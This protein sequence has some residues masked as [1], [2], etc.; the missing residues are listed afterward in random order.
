MS[1]WRDLVELLSRKDA[2]AQ[3]EEM[4]TFK[5]LSPLAAKLNWSHY[6]GEI[7]EK[8]NV[9][10]L[11]IANSDK[12]VAFYSLDVILAA[13]RFLPRTTQTRGVSDADR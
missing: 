3:R 8:S 1:E 13:R 11:H 4:R 7:D 5:I 12:S 10:N 6:Q 9:Q 2:K